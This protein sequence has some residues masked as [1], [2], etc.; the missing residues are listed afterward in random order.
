MAERF[1]IETSPEL[2]AGGEAVGRAADGRIVFIEGAV[3][4]ETVQVAVTAQN[5]RFLRA[6]VLH[7]SKPGPDRV[8]PPCGHFGVCGGC[9]LQHLAPAAQTRQKHLSVLTTVKRI[10]RLDLQTIGT[11]IE[12][13]WQGA[14]LGDRIR[15]RWLA[16]GQ[17]VGYRAAYSQDVVPVTSCPILHPRLQE[18][19]TKVASLRF[20][21]PTE[22]SAVTNGQVVHLSGAPGF[23]SGPLRHDDHFGPL[24]LDPGVFAQASLAG[25]EALLKTVAGWLPDSI[26]VALELYSGSGNFSRVLAQK[27]G[28]L[29]AVEQGSSAVKLARRLALPNVEFWDQTAEAG[30]K[31]YKGRPDL[32]LTDPPRAGMS[33]AVVA[34][35]GG[36]RAPQIVYVSCDPATF[37]R[38]LGLL[39]G[40]GYQPR[41]LRVFDLYPHTAHVEVA[42][43]LSL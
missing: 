30:L 27:S 23:E 38:D 17:S 1:E 36:L 10:G 16:D 19:L 13:P 24:W 18:A 9:S 31:R 35:L 34:A 26:S 20:S 29:V 8:T 37:A 39:A 41:R 12:A 40:H 7:I 2:A 3:P 21:K 6:R 11:E 4:S 14:S 25:N 32:V 15:A 28:K 22:L 42:T 43:L 33:P 5:P